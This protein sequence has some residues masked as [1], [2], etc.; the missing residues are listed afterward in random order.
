MGEHGRVNMFLHY[1]ETCHH[2]SAQTVSHSS[3]H[4]PLPSCSSHSEQATVQFSD[5][6]LWV[7]HMRSPT[8]STPWLTD[9]LLISATGELISW[10]ECT[11]TLW[12]S[13]CYVAST[14]LTCSCL[15][16]RSAAGQDGRTRRSTGQCLSV[17]QWVRHENHQRCRLVSMF[18]HR[19]FRTHITQHIKVRGLIQSNLSFRVLPSCCWTAVH[20]RLFKVSINSYISRLWFID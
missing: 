10:L 19:I 13:S 20:K 8:I 2:T 12:H 6:V 15:Y 7:D 9:W 1:A 11:L 4:N 5:N 14:S 17:Y 3:T 16:W 18:V